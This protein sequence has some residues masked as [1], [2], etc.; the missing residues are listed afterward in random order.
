[1]TEVPARSGHPA[2]MARTDIHLDGRLRHL[3]AAYCDS[4]HSRAS[5]SDVTRALEAVQEHLKAQQRRAPGGV[6]APGRRAARRARPAGSP[7]P[8]L[9][10]SQT[11]PK[12]SIPVRCENCAPRRSP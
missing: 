2:L 4:L 10:P 3:G 9:A 1:M 6:T 12:L 7:T 5:R 11:G 8:S